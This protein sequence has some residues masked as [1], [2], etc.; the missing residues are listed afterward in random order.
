MR[1][2]N[3]TKKFNLTSA[4]QKSMFRNMLTSLILKEKVYTTQQ[5]G[6][7]LK[8]IADRVIHSAKKDTV[9]AR[10]QVEKY[11][12][13]EKAHTKLFKD[14]A[15]RFKN[16]TGGYTRKLLAYARLGDAAQMCYVMLTDEAAAAAPTTATP[17]K[18]TAAP[19]KTAKG[20]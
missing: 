15:P 19:A 17:A 14:I 1:H 6:I 5:K 11:I 4:H 12:V 8:R 16:R 18:T 13:G 3:K 2:R 10:R 9:H 7:E 20:S